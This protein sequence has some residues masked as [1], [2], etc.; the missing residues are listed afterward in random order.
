MSEKRAGMQDIAHHTVRGRADTVTVTSWVGTSGLSFDVTDDATGLCLT[1]QS[2]DNEPAPSD[3]ESLV[4]DLA[5]KVDAGMLDR[6][7][8]GAGDLLAGVVGSR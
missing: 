5:D 4:D 6:Y 7:F 2:L 8:D 1:V 3:I